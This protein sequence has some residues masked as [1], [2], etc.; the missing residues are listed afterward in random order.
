MG[1][2]HPLH[3]GGNS[4]LTKTKRWQANRVGYCS[5]AQQR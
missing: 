4:P 1:L 5:R 2:W 3:L